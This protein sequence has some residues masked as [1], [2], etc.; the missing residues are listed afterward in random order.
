MDVLAAN[1]QSLIRTHVF[2]RVHRGI[3]TGSPLTDVKVVLMDGRSHLKHT[4][5][6]DFRQAVYRAIRQ[7]LEKA[8]NVLLEPWY[9]VEIS[10]P[11]E[12]AG[13]IM[14][15]LSKRFAQLSPMEQYGNQAV[16]RGRGPVA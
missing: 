15:E 9:E 3:L 11:A 5:G 6:G 14:A 2:E 8:D 7:G 13:R 10:A 1:Y 16:I 4:E 12:A